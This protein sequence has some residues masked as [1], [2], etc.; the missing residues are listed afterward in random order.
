MSLPTLT[1]TYRVVTPMFIG[2]ADSQGAPELRAP[3]FKGVLRFWWRAL[4]WDRFGHDLKRLR[5]EEAALFG[6]SDAGQS[7]IRLQLFPDNCTVGDSA[8]RWSRNGWEDYAGYGLRDADRRPWAPGT[9]RVEITARTVDVLCRDDLLAALKLLGLCGGLGARSRNGWG[10]LTL[11]NLRGAATWDAPRDRSS[12][13]NA[14]AQLLMLS[15]GPIPPYTAI[16]CHAAFAVG[17]EC[18]SAT[19]AHRYLSTVYRDN[20]QAAKG[21]RKD[22]RQFGLPRTGLS[23]DQRD[24]RRAKP[25]FLHVHETEEGAP[26]FPV[27]LYLPA[28]FLPTERQMPSGGAEIR[29]LIDDVKKG[30][31]PPPQGGRRR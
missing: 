30:K 22:R 29:N 28:H 16:S 15:P 10:S 20:V 5:D 31:N 18:R 14:I 21:A 12:L 17:K 2:G 8:G 6:S 19:D 3:S 13:H 26:A 7:K 4:A 24:Q 25:L 1:A 27:A 9:M 23:A 11:L